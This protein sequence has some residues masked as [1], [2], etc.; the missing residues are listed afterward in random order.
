MELAPPKTPLLVKNP[1]SGKLYG[2]LSLSQL[3]ASVSESVSYY[4]SKL[5]QALTGGGF[6]QAVPA[7]ISFAGV[8]D[9][10]KEAQ[11]SLNSLRGYA[12]LT[13]DNY[14]QQN[15]IEESYSKNPQAW[16]NYWEASYKNPR[17]EEANASL[18]IP[19]GKSNQNSE[20]SVKTDLKIPKTT[21]TGL[22]STGSINPF[23]S[24][25]SGLNI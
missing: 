8:S 3:R 15:K 25:D 16:N 21:G 10:V 18:R 1:Y 2:N 12:G 7:S 9:P 23:G 22:P 19:S 6:G 14:I 13:E 11:A 4:T 24:L 5:N 20:E 17:Q